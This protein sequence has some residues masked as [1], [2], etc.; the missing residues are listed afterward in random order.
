MQRRIPPQIELHQYRQAAALISSREAERHAFLNGLL[1]DG[2]LCEGARR[3]FL[4]QLQAQQTPAALFQLAA[5]DSLCITLRAAFRRLDT[6]L[7]WDI[8]KGE[9][10]TWWGRQALFEFNNDGRR[11]AEKSCGFWRSTGEQFGLLPTESLNEAGEPLGLRLV[12]PQGDP[13][14]RLERKDAEALLSAVLNQAPDRQATHWLRQWLDA[15]A[16]HDDKPLSLT[17]TGP[18]LAWKYGAQRQVA[19]TEGVSDRTL[20]TRTRRVEAMLSGLM[21]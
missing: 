19:A 10:A 4:K 20:R 15:D 2:D 8:E 14:D 3:S 21:V 16:L 6:L 1:E 11:H 18:R 13:A 9:L 5:E 17:A 12:D 7:T